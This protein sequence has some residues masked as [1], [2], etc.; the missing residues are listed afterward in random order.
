MTTYRHHPPETERGLTAASWKEIF[1]KFPSTTEAWVLCS[2]VWVFLII[3]RKALR[4][5]VSA[6]NEDADEEVG[7]A[8]SSIVVPAW[9]GMWRKDQRPGTAKIRLPIFS[10]RFAGYDRSRSATHFRHII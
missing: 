7:F 2:V 3:G 6:P 5:G 1:E 4:V 10:D 8:V 9:H